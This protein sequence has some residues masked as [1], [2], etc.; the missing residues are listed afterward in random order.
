MVW[1]ISDPKRLSDERRATAAIDEDWFEN[2][3][4][5][6]DSACRLRLIFDIALPHRR[7]RLAMTYHNSFPASP[8]SVRPVDDVGRISFHQYG[9]GGEFCLSIRS[10]NWSPGITGADIIRSAHTLLEVETPDEDGVISPAPSAH[11]VPHEQL[12]RHSLAR[13]YVDS[14]SG[15]AIRGG[16]LDGAPIEV[17]FDFRSPCLI[18]HLLS[19]GPHPRDDSPVRIGTPHALRDTRFVYSGCLYFVDSATAKVKAIKTVEGLRAIVGDRF[20]LSKQD[21]WACV[22]CTPD[23]EILFAKHYGD[24][25]E[26]FVF[27][28]IYEPTDPL[29]SGLDSELFAQKRVGLSVSVP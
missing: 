24:S 11:N 9:P 8:P 21:K 10:D 29:R 22:V 6:L 28:T 5:S 25:E 17:G 19:I 2:P 16:D 18:A 15:L 23:L 12:L 20:T 26:V 4:W 27:E 3:A 1:W 14:V 7:F 13:F